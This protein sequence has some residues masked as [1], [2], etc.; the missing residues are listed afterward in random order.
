MSTVFT[1]APEG[2]SPWDLLARAY[3]WT[4]H[5]KFELPPRPAL[6]TPIRPVNAAGSLR[7][8]PWWLI[9]RPVLI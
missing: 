7:C 6:Y 5:E 2:L 1:H 9:A 8:G 4:A 3:A